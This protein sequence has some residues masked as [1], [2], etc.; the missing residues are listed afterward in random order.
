VTDSWNKAD[1]HIHTQYSDGADD[2]STILAHVAE[3]TDL[4]VIAITDHDCIE[5]ALEARSL[6]PRYGLEVV[7][8]EEVSTDRGHLLALFIRHRVP[9]GLSIPETVAAVHEQGG[10]AIL[11]HPCDRICNSPLR[12]WPR[13]TL[14]DWRSFGLDGL[15]GVNGC[16]LDP[17]A[18][19]RSQA[20]ARRLC[21]AAT[22]GSDAHH[23]DAIGVAHTLFRGHTAVDL[24][25]A[26]LERT[27]VASGRRWSLAE[28]TGWVRES[29]LPRALRSLRG[30]AAMPT[31]GLG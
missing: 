31:P 16:Q 12:H 14:D 17:L 27:T 28:Y 7:V 22:G 1:L 21:L 25:R 3:R 30:P 29:M 11:A 26:L 19:P 2:I 10:I 4:R 18:N 24:R 15:E 20:L 5:G 6:A 9:S 8:G 13:P 23:K